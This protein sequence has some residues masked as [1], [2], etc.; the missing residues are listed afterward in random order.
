MKRVEKR[1]ARGYVDIPL[2][3]DVGDPLARFIHFTQ[4]KLIM[5]RAITTASETGTLTIVL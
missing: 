5:G 3:N 1:S 2:E 4:P